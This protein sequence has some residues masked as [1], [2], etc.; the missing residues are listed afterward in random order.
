MINPEKKCETYNAV[1]K[2]IV[3]TVTNISGITS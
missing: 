3:I 1:Q 2:Y